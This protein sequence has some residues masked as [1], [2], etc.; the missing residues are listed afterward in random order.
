MTKIVLDEQQQVK[1]AKYISKQLIKAI[2]IKEK[3]QK[4]PQ[5]QI[6]KIETTVQRKNLM[7]ALM[8]L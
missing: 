4:S 6:T 5:T 1:L 8:F 7:N 2:K 3:Q